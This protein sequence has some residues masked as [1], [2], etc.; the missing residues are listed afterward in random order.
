MLCVPQAPRDARVFDIDLVRQEP[1]FLGRGGERV[2]A[3]EVV[4]AQG[5]LFG[6]AKWDDGTQWDRWAIT[7]V[8]N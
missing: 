3:D 2:Y 6:V 4:F 8:S 7:N 5:S 1:F